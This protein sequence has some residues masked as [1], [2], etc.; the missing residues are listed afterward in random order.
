MD[1]ETSTT[2]VSEPETTAPEVAEPVPETE[3][4]DAVDQV[5]GGAGQPESKASE[6]AAIF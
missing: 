4:S 1:P 3:S 2:A 6:W 5:E